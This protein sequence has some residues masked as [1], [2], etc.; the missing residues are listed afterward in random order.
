[1]FETLR[2]VKRSNRRVTIAKSAWS[3]SGYDH[4]VTT[5]GWTR[6][7]YTPE[8]DRLTAMDA[9]MLYLENKTVSFDIAGVFRV[10]GHVDFDAYVVDLA[11]RLEY[12]PRFRQRILPV[13]FNL[14]H[15][16]WETDPDFDLQDHVRHVRLPAP[17]S[18]AEFD[19]FLDDTM[20]DRLDMSKPPWMLY[21]VN[22]LENDEAAI[23]IKVHHCLTDGTGGHKIYAAL[24]DFQEPNM[25]EGAAPDWNKD[26]PPLPRPLE[27]VRHAI[28][29][30]GKAG[31]DSSAIG[32]APAEELERREALLQRFKKAPAM[33]FGFNGMLSGRVQHRSTSFPLK[34]L[35]AIRKAYGATINDVFISMLGEISERIAREEG[36]DPTGRYLRLHLAANR[37]NQGT[38][39]DWGNRVALLP[40]LIPLDVKDP[41]QRL[42]EVAEYMREVKSANVIEAMVEYINKTQRL[43]APMLRW[44]LRF[45]YSD[46]LNRAIVKI[47]RPPMMNMYVTNVR[48]PEVSSY[49]GGRKVVQVRPLLP[50]MPRV[51]LLCSAITYS[52]H[53]TLSFAG[54][55][56][57][58]QPLEKLIKYLHE[59]FDR[60]LATVDAEAEGPSS[61]PAAMSHAK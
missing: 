51:G 16:T 9:T 45:M 13:P 21:V 58:N 28:A 33:R 3:L 61:E 11:H 38:K 17:G 14:G 57:L 35:R 23:V 46:L 52:D 4:T 10:D 19:V 25:R 26:A 49:M 56:T 42:K 8:R 5:S 24:V 54:D 7:G 2:V 12:L 39:D 47:G 53:L 31:A 20:Q 22:G 27:R 44:V 36:Q 18:L 50:L 32:V 55:P 41:G 43:P 1:M 59:A 48:W 34:D 30:R 15:P 60:L 40:A 37:R 29:D 6:R